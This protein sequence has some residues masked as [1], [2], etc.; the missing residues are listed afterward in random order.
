MT[1]AVQRKLGEEL[2]R[3]YT[4]DLPVHGWYR[5]ILSFPPHLVRKYIEVFDLADDAVVLDPF[6]GTGTTLVECKKN[7]IASVGL[8][9]NPVV[10]FAASVKTSWNANFEMLQPHADKIAETTW[11]ALAQENI[12][13]VP[14]ELQNNG[15]KALRQ[16][17]EEKEKLIIKN[18][19]SP[20]PLH[21]VLV[22]I[23]K[24]NEF[25]CDQFTPYE[26][27]ALAKELVF[28]ISNLK[29]G[30]EVGVG[31][32]KDD[33]EVVGV[34]KRAVASIAK[35]LE[36]VQSSENVPSV[37]HLADSRK[38][39]DVIAPQKKIDAV[40]TSPPYPNEK[41]YSR[42]TR[43]ESVLLD[44][45]RDKSDLQKHKRTLLRSNTRGI[46]KSDE[47]EKWISQNNRIHQL[48]KEIETKR[49]LLGKTSG[50]EKL[51]HRVVLLYFGGV[52][53]HLEDLKNYLKPGAKLAYVVG[54]Q[55]SYLQVMIRTGEIIAEIAEQR[56]YQVT[57][58]DL[59]RTRFSTATGQNLREEV[60]LLKWNG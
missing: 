50:F 23:E 6:C 7:G 49:I 15:S 59:F 14:F 60:V 25:S 52:A 45:M 53:R 47:D 55:A 36:T 30:P 57:G 29:F 44:F 8:E 10:H 51:Y 17:S 48:A 3:F 42:T 40:I 16:L 1:Y 43:L 38:I 35:D 41:D 37:V 28:S 22:L 31:K 13:D 11:E 9:A 2:N 54:D 4:E 5:F 46:Y 33:S 34:W 56:G 19:I 39:S 27:L 58:I 12:S 24:I 20:L 26:R 18:S 32:K 21:K